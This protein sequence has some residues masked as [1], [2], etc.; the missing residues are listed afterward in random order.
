MGARIVFIDKCLP[1][2]GNHYLP[3]VSNYC[4]LRNWGHFNQYLSLFWV[5]CLI[6]L[7][8]KKKFHIQVSND[9]FIKMVISVIY[10]L[11]KSFKNKSC[12]GDSANKFWIRR[13]EFTG[14]YFS[15]LWS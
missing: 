11:I 5:G 1:Q 10:H 4:K 12:F 6:Y 13:I 7:V 9:Y 15:W 8:V 3:R 2:I 14:I